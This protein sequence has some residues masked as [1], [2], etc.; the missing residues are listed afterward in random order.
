MMMNTKRR[1]L[2]TPPPP[3]PT[4]RSHHTTEFSRTTILHCVEAGS[5]GSPICR[6]GIGNPSKRDRRD[7]KS[8][9]DG[10]ALAS[11]CSGQ[12]PTCSF[13]LIRLA[14]AAP[15]AAS[16]SSSTKSLNRDVT[17]LR[18]SGRPCVPIRSRT[19]RR[20]NLVSFSGLDQ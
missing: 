4:S 16:C 11:S 20:G 13:S 6:C 2:S 9:S 14:F 15:S 18:G 17:G 5:A 10:G 12:R 1:E 3:P 8:L 19:Q 7:E